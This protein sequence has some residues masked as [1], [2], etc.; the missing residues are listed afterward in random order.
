MVTSD[1]VNLKEGFMK[2]LYGLVV[3]SLSM[4]IILSGSHGARADDQTQ[5]NCES[6]CP[7]GQKVV[8]FTDGDNV[9][10]VCASETEMVATEPDSSLVDS[11]EYEDEGQKE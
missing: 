6:N 1:V 2:Y 8:S 4:I 11:G 10:C 7:A 5:T 9:A 3:F